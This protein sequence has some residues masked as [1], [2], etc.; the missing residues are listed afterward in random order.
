MAK[1]S[2]FDG[3][4]CG[5]RVKRRRR[6]RIRGELN[7]FFLGDSIRIL[8]GN[9]LEF[10]GVFVEFDGIGGGN[11][12]RSVDGK[13]VGTLVAPMFDVEMTL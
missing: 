10:R 11:G 3:I 8:L 4:V 2:V 9:M 1:R 6:R 5:R 12:L 13:R 7:D